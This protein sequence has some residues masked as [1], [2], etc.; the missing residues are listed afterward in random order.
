M[1]IRVQNEILDGQSSNY[2]YYENN[3]ESRGMR[4][5]GV[6]ETEWT[7]P[8]NI[9]DCFYCGVLT[10]FC[11]NYGLSVFISWLV[12]RMCTL[13]FFILYSICLSAVYVYVHMYSSTQYRIRVWCQPFLYL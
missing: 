2:Q 7:N 11:G 8:P 10:F 6:Y 1:V 13:T 3:L 9:H 5:G 12:F 4:G